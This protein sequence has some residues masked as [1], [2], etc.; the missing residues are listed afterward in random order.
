MIDAKTKAWNRHAA[1]VLAKAAPARPPENIMGG[2]AECGATKKGVHKKNCW[3]VRARKLIA[4]LKELG[5]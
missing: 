3:W 1:R 4:D 5:K 2:C